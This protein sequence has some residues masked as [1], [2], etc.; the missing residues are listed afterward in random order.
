MAIISRPGLFSIVTRPVDRLRHYVGW[1][2]KPNP[3]VV[4]DFSHPSRRPPPA[5][6]RR[7]HSWTLPILEEV[8]RGFEAHR[9]LMEEARTH[10]RSRRSFLEPGAGVEPATY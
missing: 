5:H 9:A 8:V 4:I 6:A 3:I 1:Q 7:S 2:F 10:H